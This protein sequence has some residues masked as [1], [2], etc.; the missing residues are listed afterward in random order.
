M[1]V[2][3]KSEDRWAWSTLVFPFCALL[4]PLP[5]LFSDLLCFNYPD[6]NMYVQKAV[7]IGQGRGGLVLLGDR[8]ALFPYV[9]HHYCP[10]S[11]RPRLTVGYY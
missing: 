9:L 4:I 8:T 1:L 10:V 2:Q 5:Y 7:E 11:K 6:M 3:N